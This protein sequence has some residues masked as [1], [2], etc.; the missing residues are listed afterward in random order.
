MTISCAISADTVSGPYFF[1][2]VEIILR[3]LQGEEIR[4]QQGGAIHCK[5]INENCA[6]DVPTALDI[7][8]L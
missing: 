7:A 3:D 4:F 8:A 6:R 5:T 1:E 2:D